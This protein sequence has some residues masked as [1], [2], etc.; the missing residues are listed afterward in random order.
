MKTVQRMSFAT[1]PEAPAYPAVRAGS[2]AHGTPCV[3]QETA[4]AMVSIHG[5]PAFGTCFDSFSCGRS[6]L[7]VWALYHCLCFGW[8]QTL[9]DVSLF[10][11]PGVCQAND[12]DGTDA[13]IL[14]GVHKHNNTSEHPAKKPPNGHQT[15]A[16]KGERP[17]ENHRAWLGSRFAQMSLCR[18]LH[19][20]P[21]L[22]SIYRPGRGHM[23]EICRLLWG[24]L[25]RQTLL[26]SH[27]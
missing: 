14:P 10:T 2:G 3:V 20:H 13:S 18:V 19:S 5:P 16:A 24:S 9:N 6:V 7:H 23:P 15:T 22:T 8:Q 17:V 25:L 1:M 12:I 11:F 26:V 4:A 27:L 21:S